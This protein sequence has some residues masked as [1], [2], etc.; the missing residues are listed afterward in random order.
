MTEQ[1]FIILD[2]VE[3][4]N[5][6]LISS[7]NNFVDNGNTLVIIPPKEIDKISNYNKK[8]K[9]LGVNTIS[10]EMKSQFKINKF[11]FNHPI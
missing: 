9:K 4:L 5:S 3:N 2:G 8:L 7:L 10:K 1:N 11:D 6:G